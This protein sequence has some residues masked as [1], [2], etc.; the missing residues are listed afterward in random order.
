MVK[1]E[2]ITGLD[3]LRGLG[4]LIVVMSHTGYSGEFVRCG[5]IFTI[6]LFYVVAGC[7]FKDGGSFKS[8]VIN[9]SR[10]IVVPYFFYLLA[11]L[12]VYFAGNCLLLKQPFDYGLFN[13][14]STERY[15]L[16]YIA[17]LWFFESIFWCYLLYGLLRRLTGNDLKLGIMTFAIGVAGWVLSV[18]T[19]LPLSLDSSMSWL[20]LFYLGNMMPR[21][22][23]GKKV[24]EGR[25][26]AA[27]L[28][29]AVIC[30]VIYMSTDYRTGYCYNVIL[31]DIPLNVALTMTATLGV[32]AFCCRI[33][34]V[35]LLSYF[36]RNSLIIFAGHQIFC[37]LI[38]QG[39]IHLHLD[40]PPS[41]LRYFLLPMTIIG[42]LILGMLLRK[43]APG[44]VGERKRV[45][46]DE[47][48][49][50]A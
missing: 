12:A 39:A 5:M 11:G 3:T 50:P 9:K 14:L 49:Q 40:I 42:S 25:Y 22:D 33:G 2:R 38:E 47:R 31:G 1:S 46:A 8:L 23:F 6:P 29:V 10:R 28:A 17:S 21:H 13:I 41:T 26:G 27:G 18:V 45:R 30:A 16:P 44:L 32:T 34:Y 24:L 19:P 4:I 37:I 35:P 48:V 7:L 15:A 43:Y 36:G 20:P